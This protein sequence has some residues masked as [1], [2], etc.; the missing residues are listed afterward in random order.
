M[1]RTV[2][3]GYA[4]QANRAQVQSFRGGNMHTEN[5]KAVIDAFASNPNISGEAKSVVGNIFR[6]IA[7][8]HAQNPMAHLGAEDFLEYGAKFQEA[9]RKS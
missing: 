2:A 4:A 1:I 6:Q 8:T 7:A 9:A 5:V 3:T